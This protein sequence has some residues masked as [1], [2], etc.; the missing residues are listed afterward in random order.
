MILIPTGQAPHKEI[1]GDPGGEVRLRMTE[2]AVADDDR[3]EVSSIEVERDEPS[4]TA[5]TLALLHER[6][7]GREFVFVLEIGRASCRERV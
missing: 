5:R 1:E 6:Y 7:P 3:F 2:A 4:Y